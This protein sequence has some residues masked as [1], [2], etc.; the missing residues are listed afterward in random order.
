MSCQKDVRFSDDFGV[1]RPLNA[2]LSCMVRGEADAGS[3]RMDLTH[4]GRASSKTELK[5]QLEEWSRGVLGRA[6]RV[7]A[8]P[9][10]QA[11]SASYELRAAVDHST[12]VIARLD[13]ISGTRPATFTARARFSGGV[14]CA[15]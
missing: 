2:E 12:Q 7:S 5:M 11:Q 15:R 10:A 14:R 8:S 6:L 4:W 9:P 1:A 3:E 13:C